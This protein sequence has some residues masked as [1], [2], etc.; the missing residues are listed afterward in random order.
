MWQGCGQDARQGLPC[1]L[2][3]T[4]QGRGRDAADTWQGMAGG[5]VQAG[6]TERRKEDESRCGAS[7]PHG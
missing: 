7:Q 5:E 4:Q 6:I 2:D 1:G 3:G